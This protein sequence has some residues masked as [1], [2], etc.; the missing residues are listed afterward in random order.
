MGS[1]INKIVV[2]GAGGVGFP[3]VDALCRDVPDIEI[4]VYDDDDYNG[5]F[6]AQRLPYV[7]NKNTKKVAALKG[8][9]QMVMRDKAPFVY[10]ERL[11]EPT[12]D[13]AWGPSVLV[14]DCTDM[15]LEARRP[16]WA[17]LRELGCQMLRVSYDGN[18]I[19]VVARGLPLASKPG[20][21]YSQ[22]PSRAQSLWAGGVG[23]A[24]VEKLL[25]GEV[26]NDYQM[27]IK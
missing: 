8:Y 24:A 10:V 14:V 7:G 18:G 22:V 21:G 17:K 1:E 23:A 20:G 2:L 27:E 5:G 13:G 25:R 15:G 12:N 3:L 26:V 16:L 6:G 19:V 9:I 11:V 4:H